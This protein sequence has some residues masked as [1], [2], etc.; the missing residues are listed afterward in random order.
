[1][2]M[3]H[4][5]H[6]SLREFILEGKFDYVEIGQSKEWL[7]HNFLDPDD[8][9]PGDKPFEQVTVWRFGNIE[10]HFAGGELTMIFM[11]YLPILDGGPSLTID[12]WLLRDSEPMTL[13]QVIWELNQA[14]ADYS[15]QNNVFE[16]RT[17]IRVEQSHVTLAFD[18]TISEQIELNNRQLS[19]IFLS[20]ASSF[21]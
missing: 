4:P 12:K 6:I 14:Q 1:M 15:V 21:S 20:G 18:S 7:K 5:I 17:E 13:A 19:S 8:W 10:F 2:K 9:G 3:S 11:D 16:G